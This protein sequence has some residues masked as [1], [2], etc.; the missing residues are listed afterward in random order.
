MFPIYKVVGLC[1][2]PSYC[3]CN[4]KLAV[5]VELRLLE[6][7]ADSAAHLGEVVQSG[8]F[9]GG[10]AAHHFHSGWWA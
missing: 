5:T 9:R 2:T 4:R 1:M 10:G 7:L 6:S 3:A 8:V